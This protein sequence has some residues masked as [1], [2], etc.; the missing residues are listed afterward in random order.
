MSKVHRKR[1]KKY[2]PKPCYLPPIF[3]NSKEMTTDLQLPGHIFIEAMKSGHGQEEMGHSLAAML[4]IGARLSEHQSQEV[5]EAM[6]AALDAAQSM[7]DRGNRTGKWGL[8]GNE[9]KAISEGVDL[10]NEMYS[11]SMRRQVMQAINETMKVATV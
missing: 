4:N 5:Q 8:S 11:A 7:M 10:T 2:V 1:N 3:G 6:S 9:M